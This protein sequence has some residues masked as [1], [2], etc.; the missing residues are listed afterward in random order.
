MRMTRMD[1]T[2]E[3]IAVDIVDSIRNGRMRPGD[4]LPKIN[5]MKAQYD[6]GYHT[7]RQARLLLLAGR[8]VEK[9]GKSL[10]VSTLAPYL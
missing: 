6:C 8:W 7:V 4:T 1:R 5:D 10:T 3:R 2:F 9:E